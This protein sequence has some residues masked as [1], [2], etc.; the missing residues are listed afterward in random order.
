MQLLKMVDKYLGQ[1]AK[2]EADETKF[3][4]GG[5]EEYALLTLV[6]LRLLSPLSGRY[7]LATF[8]AME[9]VD[10]KQRL[11]GDTK[12]LSVQIWTVILP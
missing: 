9:C 3:F 6:N 5:R 7:G 2:G 1:R 8:S 10:E 12:A 11:E 4:T